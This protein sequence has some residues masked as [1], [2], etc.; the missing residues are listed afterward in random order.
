MYTK[1]IGMHL[2]IIL[3]SK[4]YFDEWFYA[5]IVIIVTTKSRTRHQSVWKTDM[6]KKIEDEKIIIICEEC[7]SGFV[8]GTSKMMNICPECAHYLYGYP[9]CNHVFQN[10]KCIYCGW[11]GSESD[12]IKR[13]KQ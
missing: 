5:T 2:T 10:G 12:Y 13:L 6:K 9:N 8:S 4:Y 1:S 3:W 7:R 11:D